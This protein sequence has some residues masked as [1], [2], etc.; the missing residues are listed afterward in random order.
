ML[1]GKAGIH[2]FSSFLWVNSKAMLFS[3]DKITN[4]G[5]GKLKPVELHLKIDLT[6]H[7]VS[8]GGVG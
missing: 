3:L 7:P 6:S 8:G 4:L 1:L 2:L 5:A